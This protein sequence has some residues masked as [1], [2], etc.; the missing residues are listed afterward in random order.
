MNIRKKTMF[1]LLFLFFPP[2]QTFE[3]VCR[4]FVPRNDK[5]IRIRD[6]PAD[7]RSARLAGQVSANLDLDPILMNPFRA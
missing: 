5:P 7:R 3:G 4:T 1:W 2:K 6:A